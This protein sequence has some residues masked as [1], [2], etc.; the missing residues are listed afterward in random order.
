MKSLVILAD[1]IYLTPYFSIYRELLEKESIDID[2]IYWDRHWNE[3]AADEHHF[4]FVSSGTTKLGKVLDYIRFR[5]F[6]LKH[7]QTKEYDLI[8][9]LHSIVSFILGSKLP[10]GYKGRYIYDVRDYSYEWFPPFR[11][12]QTKLVSSSLVNVISSPGY[13]TF[14]PKG[15]YLIAHNLPKSDVSSAK[16][17]ETRIGKTVH[18]SYI[19]LIR[20]QEQNRKI[21]DFFANDD[22]FYLHFI[23]T[24]ANELGDYCQEKGVKNVQLVDTFAPSDTLSYYEKTDMILNLYG[25]NTP[26]LDYALSNKLYYAA[27]LYKPILVCP[28]TYMAT[29][30]T[31]GNFGYVLAMETHE[32]KNELYHYIQELNRSRLIQDCD[33]FMEKVRRE[34]QR[35]EDILTN[36]L[37]ELKERSV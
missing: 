23:G 27:S 14:L 15:D 12:H 36:R 4:R 3:V 1:N 8:I 25:N 30:S 26:L 32:E 13:Q 37:K 31:S 16:Q 34:S 6:I 7:L 29:I 18:L 10:M 20:F 28:D 24:G 33:D 11:W 17:Y 19:G 5:Q 21:I 22:R 9:P 35:T 2:I